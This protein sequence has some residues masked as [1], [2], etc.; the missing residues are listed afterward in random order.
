MT[1]AMQVRLDNTA[2]ADHWGKN[3]LLSFSEREACIHATEATGGT[4]VAVQRAARRLDGMGVTDIALTGDNWDLESRWS[5]WA[6]YYNPNRK[7]SLDWGIGEGDERKELDA[8]KAASI[9]VREITNGSPENIFPRALAESAA[10]MLQSL[11]PD[12]V[13]YRIVSGEEL[14]DEGFMGI[15]NVGRGSVRGGAMLQLDYNPTGDDAAP[16]DIC[17]VGKGITFDSGGYSIKPS[18]GMA[19]MKS[20][21]GGA[22]MVSGG[23]ALAIARGLKKRVKLYLCCAENLISGHAFKLGDVIRYKNGVTAEILNTDAEGRLVLAD[24]LIEASEQNPRY[25]LDAATLTGAAKMAVGRDYNSVLSFEDEMAEKVLSAAKSENEKAWRLPLEKF[26]LEQIPSGFAE[27]A[28]VGMD[29]TPGASTAAAFLAKF[30]R[31]EGRGWVHM[32]LSGSYLP[33]PNDQWAQG[34][35]GHGFRTIARFLLDN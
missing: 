28:N 31:D 29:G 9:W 22:A 1:T 23:L 20:D 2:A 10:D 8:R 16:V 33:G 3:A 24:G 30:V 34:A 13:S 7:S 26:H 19:H 15:H 6:G 17:L 5:F 27:I 35:K 11:A 14:L 25:I 32:D 21:M 4:L 18:A 12:A